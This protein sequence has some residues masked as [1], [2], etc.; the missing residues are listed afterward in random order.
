MDS[1]PLLAGSPNSML[2]PAR[3]GTGRLPA[4]VVPV[5]AGLR[6]RLLPSRIAT[7]HFAI[8]R[9]AI[10]A[11]LRA[12]LP[13]SRPSRAPTARLAIHGCRLRP[14][15]CAPMRAA[16]PRAPATLRATRNTDVADMS[17][18][19]MGASV[20]Q[21]PRHVRRYV[22]PCNGCIRVIPRPATWKA[23]PIWKAKPRHCYGCR[24]VP[25][26]VWVHSCYF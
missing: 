18:H 1:A 23:M 11:S 5:A 14:A 9:P 22:P 20:L 4:G 2:D 15:C 21:Y 26:S 7:A 16:T 19:A 24:H 25:P 8:A 3:L 6:A 10:V 12:R 13:P 17:P